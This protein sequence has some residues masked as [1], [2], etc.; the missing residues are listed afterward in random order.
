MPLHMPHP[1]P[2]LP[3]TIRSGV[4]N[5]AGHPH[6]STE[7]LRGATPDEVDVSTPHQIFTMGLDDL[8][9][10]R[11]L[12]A[13]WSVGWRYIVEAAGRPISSAETTLAE[14]GT[15]HLLSHVNEGPFVG[16]TADAVRA[17]QARPEL[18]AADYELRLLRIPAIYVMALWLHSEAT[19]LLVPLA[20]SPVGKE[21]HV[22]PAAELMSELSQLAR[23][24][25]HHV[26]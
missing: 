3:D 16:A 19:D 26:R 15:T 17:V 21:G 20:P 13:A 11:G 5:L 9:A 8:A 18:Q 6:I 2:G 23:S 4:R 25:P 1:P 24:A 12:D 7:A 14:D 10:G 22:V